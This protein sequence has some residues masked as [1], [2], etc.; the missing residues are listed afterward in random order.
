MERTKYILILLLLICSSAKAQTDYKTEIYKSFVNNDMPKWKSTI[1]QM[2]LQS[3]KTNDIV[4][5]LVNYQYGYIAWCL[6]N[7][8]DEEAEKYLKLITTNVESLEKQ[9]F[10]PSYILSYKSALIGFEL[11]LAWYKA[12]FIGPKSITYAENAIKTDKTNPFGYIQY[13]NSQFYM[14]E[15]FGGSKPLAI[16][17]YKIAK[18]IMEKDNYYLS[19]N[20]NYLNLLT[21]IAQAYTAV[22]NYELAKKYY[23]KIIKLEPNYNWVKKELYPELLKKMSHDK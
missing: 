8:K 17:Y 18:M 20:W 23:E 12:P 7:E 15:T 3:S 6:G 10:K 4:L 5:E 21:T 11:G 13:A 9:N 22:E 16:E 1:D 14:P 2:N 19:N